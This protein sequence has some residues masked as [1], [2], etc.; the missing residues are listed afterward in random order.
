M[1]NKFIED[2]KKMSVAHNVFDPASL[3][4][5]VAM[6]TEWIPVKGAGANF[7]THKLVTV[8][9]NRMEFRSSIEG[10]LLGLFFLLIGLGTFLGFSFVKVSSGLWAFDMETL[11]LLLGLVFAGV[12]AAML[13]FGTAP[14]VFD[15]IKGAFWKGRGT[16]EG[17]N[18]TSL[19]YFAELEQIH[20]LQIISK[21][22]RREKHF[23]YSYELNLV[24]KNGQRINVVDHSKKKILQED[25]A[26]LSAFLEK[27]VWDASLEDK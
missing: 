6:L 21:Y 19:K 13:Y 9:P 12:G 16:P 27:P 24:L 26:S 10:K 18:K 17:S 2:M 22:M 3:D 5:P 11:A 4:D 8:S 25:A 15:K 23:R 14:I 7:R 1:F 20:A